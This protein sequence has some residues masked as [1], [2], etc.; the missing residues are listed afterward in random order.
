VRE[1]N[2]NAALSR[3]DVRMLRTA[4]DDLTALGLLYERRLIFKGRYRREAMLAAA[5]RRHALS[6]LKEADHA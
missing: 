2:E 6:I 1:R 5:S 3:D 4:I